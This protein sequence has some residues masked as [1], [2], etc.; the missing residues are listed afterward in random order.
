MNIICRFSVLSFVWALLLCSC[1]Q[2]K[3]YVPMCHISDNYV[4]SVPIDSLFHIYDVFELKV[5]APPV[6]KKIMKCDSSVYVSD[7]KKLYVYNTGG[8]FLGIISK[9]GRGPGEYV[10]ILDFDCSDNCIFIIDRNGKLL[11]YSLDGEC[12]AEKRTGWYPAAMCVFGNALIL[13]SACQTSGE[14][15]KVLD[16]ES[17][18]EKSAFG[19]VSESELTWRHFMNQQNF[20]QTSKEVLFHEPMSNT[21]SSIDLDNRTMDVRY[22]LDFINAVPDKV[23]NN[24][25]SSV[26]DMN[27]AFLAGNYSAGTPV[28]VESER[29]ILFSFRAGETYRMG[30]YDLVDKESIQFDAIKLNGNETSIPISSLGAYFYSDE[31]SFLIISDGIADRKLVMRVSL[32]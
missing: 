11:K 21:I 23:L 1:S 18:E 20:Y 2:N 19:M 26:M 30:R 10:D 5:E 24:R 31:N 28:Y 8:S 9:R 12:V 27:K 3:D 29:S 4:E 17:L 14:K 13:S 7:G 6:A 16:K 22:I 15:I 25:Y 32:R